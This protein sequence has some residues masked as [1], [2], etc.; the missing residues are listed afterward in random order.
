MNSKEE[1]EDVDVGAKKRSNSY[2]KLGKFS[3]Q[4]NATTG[5][6]L[7]GFQTVVLPQ[8]GA[9]T[10]N[11]VKHFEPINPVAFGVL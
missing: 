6:G 11:A 9:P 1:D 10:V 7:P 4:E 5:S 3:G 8:T 2:D